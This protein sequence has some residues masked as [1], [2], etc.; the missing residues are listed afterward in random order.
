MGYGSTALRK[1]KET[2]QLYDFTGR[3]WLMDSFQRVY[4][5]AIP[6]SHSPSSPF[7]TNDTSL[8]V[9]VLAIAVL[10]LAM[11]AISRL[12]NK[13]PSTFRGHKLEVSLYPWKL[14]SPLKSG[15]ISIGNIHR[16]Q[17]SIF[18]GHSFVFRGFG[19]FHCWHQQLIDA[20]K[21]PKVRNMRPARCSSWGFSSVEVEF[22]YTKICNK[23][24]K[25]WSM[26]MILKTN[27]LPF[28]PF[29]VWK[30]LM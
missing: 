27:H 9:F 13:K 3:L 16:L 8:S 17:P 25:Y 7:T 18:R 19:P 30:I 10:W 24:C 28:T 26:S 20:R 4:D 14:T 6:R 22:G 15:T 29:F 21:I 2:T 23:S 1:M 11:R 12:D 5:S